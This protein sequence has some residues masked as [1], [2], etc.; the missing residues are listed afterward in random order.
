MKLITVLIVFKF[1]LAQ[2][3][4]LVNDLFGFKLGQFRESTTNTLGPIFKSDKFPDNSEFEIF[5]LKPDSSAYIYFEYSAVLNN[6]IWA[7]QISGTNTELDLGFKNLKLGLTKE[8]VEKILG[9]ASS[10]E[11]LDEYGESWI[12][13]D[14]NYNVEI[15]LEGKLSSVKIFNPNFINSLFTE[16]KVPSFESIL[17][18]LQSENNK[19]IASI[20]STDFELF[21]NNKSSHFKKSWSEEINSDFSKIFTNI[22]LVSKDLEKINTKNI[23][24]H[25]NNKNQEKNESPLLIF[26][27][28]SSLIVKEIVFKLVN[29]Q[30]LISEIRCEE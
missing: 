4:E 16:A 26:K 21:Y 9:K 15:S 12:Y 30:F 8:K 27:I 1:I 2:K 29:T 3:P 19:T 22:T 14:A 25:K 20:L 24:L 28:N 6:I 10:K 17:A 13:K 7:I 11:N 5:V 23:S 18:K